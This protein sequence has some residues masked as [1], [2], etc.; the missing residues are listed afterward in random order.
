M[1]VPALQRPAYGMILTFPAAFGAVRRRHDLVHAQG[2]VTSTADVV[3]AH[4]VLQAWRTA[5]RG[6]GVRAPWLG[7]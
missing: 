4:I 1:H 5:A 2:W 7:W 6:A 3:T